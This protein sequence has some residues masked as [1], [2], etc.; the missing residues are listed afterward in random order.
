MIKRINDRLP[1]NG[2]VDKKYRLSSLGPI[3]FNLYLIGICRRATI[4]EICVNSRGVAW[5]VRT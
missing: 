2:E 1:L 3:N 4:F 5:G